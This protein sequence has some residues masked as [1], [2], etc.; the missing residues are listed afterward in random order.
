M[1]AKED[2]FAEWNDVLD[3]GKFNRFF[4]RVWRNQWEPIFKEAIDKASKFDEWVAE[5]AAAG[6]ADADAA[7]G[8]SENQAYAEWEESLREEADHA[9]TLDNWVR[10]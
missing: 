9:K 5:E 1:T 3:H 8:E 7:I 10:Q 6:Q 4:F 2:P